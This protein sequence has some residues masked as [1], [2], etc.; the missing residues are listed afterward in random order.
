MPPTIRPSVPIINTTKQ[1]LAETRERSPLDRLFEA[2]A[3]GC[4][5][6]ISEPSRKRETAAN[7][8]KGESTIPP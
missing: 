1:L 8:P 3:Q 6:R 5:A 4:H 2:M 7:S